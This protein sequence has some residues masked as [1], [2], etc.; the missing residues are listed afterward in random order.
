MTPTTVTKTTNWPRVI[1]VLLLTGPLGFA[2]L[3]HLDRRA[4]R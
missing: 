1:A 2:M 3:W 4:R